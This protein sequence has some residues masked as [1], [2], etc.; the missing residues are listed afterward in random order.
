MKDVVR[1]L[2]EAAHA[3]S[4]LAHHLWVLTFPIVWATLAERKEQQI[5]LAKPIIVLLQREYHL[6]QS[7][8]RPNVVQVGHLQVPPC[9]QTILRLSLLYC[10]HIV[11]GTAEEIERMPYI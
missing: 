5:A 11:N 9:I 6:R 8:M 4:S 10:L 7:H 1:P 2:R 3:E